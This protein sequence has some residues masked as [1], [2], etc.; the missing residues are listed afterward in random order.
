[1]CACVRV[2][3]AWTET[4]TDK[5]TETDTYN[6]IFSYTCTDI[7]VYTYTYTHTYSDTYTYTC[8]YSHIHMCTYAHIHIYTHTHTHTHTHTLTHTL[9]THTHTHTHTRTHTPRALLCM[10]RDSSRGALE[11]LNNADDVAVEVVTCGW[12][13]I[14]SAG[15]PAERQ[16]CHRL[17]CRNV[18]RHILGSFV[19][20]W[21]SFA[22]MYISFD[23]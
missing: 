17:I 7:S 16:D 10:A 19:A 2:Y 14:D 9:N 1:M 13:H 4:D 22:K 15:T 5:D 6:P 8:M 21:V 3:D 23:V 12:E 20:M 18:E 11:W